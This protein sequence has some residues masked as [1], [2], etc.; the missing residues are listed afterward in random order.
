MTMHFAIWQIALYGALLALPMTTIVLI[1]LS[2][3][4]LRQRRRATQRRWSRWLNNLGFIV[5]APV[6]IVGA[7]IGLVLLVDGMIDEMHEASRHFT[8][9][10]SRTID[11]I[12]LPPG[13]QVNL[14]GY[15]RLA[16][17]TLPYGV[18]LSLAGGIW[19]GT[20]EFA[21]AAGSDDTKRTRM[22]AATLDADAALDGIPCQGGQAV[23]F[24]GS[25][26]VRAC[27]LASATALRTDIAPG[28]S[29]NVACAADHPLE[30]QPA[31]DQQV[32]VCTLV[33]M[34]EL[35]GILCAAAAEVEIVNG[36][37]IRCTLAAP[38]S[39]G[40][41]QIPAGSILRLAD[42]PQRI[43]R[44]S[45][46]A[47]DARFQAFGMALPPGAEVLLCRDA[48]AVDQIQLATDSYVDIGGVK[49]TG[50][51]NFQC[52]RF[53]YGTLFEDTRLHGEPWRQGRTVF[54][55]DLELPPA[56]RL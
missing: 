31:A 49:L 52:G 35:Q 32:A 14:D 15:D 28:T 9:T 26:G 39:A 34:V 27:T 36:R 6:W 42:T 3:D 5:V 18:T 16:D 48:W 13:T 24:W 56:S 46:P 55:E 29:V 30:L 1:A 44:F 45:V 11:G 4:R 22:R 23:A 20:I 37:L 7:A 51:I 47:M 2:I 33:D 54:R 50:F 25:G 12:E 38:H 8:V 41:L 40:D 21:S 17:I 53:H 43:E 19:R 10:A